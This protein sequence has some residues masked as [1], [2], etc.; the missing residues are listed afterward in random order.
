MA[1]GGALAARVLLLVGSETGNAQDA[2]EQVAREAARRGY[3]ARVMSMGDY[4]AEEL[5]GEAVVVLVVATT[6]QGEVPGSMKR[7]WRY[8]LR[9]SLPRDWLRGTCYAV[10]GLGDSAYQLFN[11][12][13]KKLDR[14][15]MDLG[16]VPLL[17]RGLGDD[18]HPCGYA[19]ALD[20]WLSS[21]WAV[22]P[23]PPPSASSALSAVDQPRL[24]VQVLS[25]GLAHAA[26]SPDAYTAAPPVAPPAPDAPIAAGDWVPWSKEMAEA[27]GMMDVALSA[28][29]TPHTSANAQPHSPDAPVSAPTGFTP[30][31]P[32]LLEATGAASPATAAASGDDGAAE[33]RRAF[34]RHHPFLATLEVNR[35]LTA[36]GHWQD[37]RHI[38]LNTHGGPEYSPGDVLHVFPSQPRSAVLA[39]LHRCNLHPHMQVVVRAAGLTPSSPAPARSMSL[40]SL[41]AATLDINSASPR[42]YFFE[43]LG[44]F[45]SDERE[46]EKLAWLASPEGRE[47]LHEYNQRERRT[48]LEVLQEFPS[49][50]LPL[51]WLLQ[52]CPRLQ[53]RSFSISSSPLAHPARCHLTAALVS[54]TT[55][56]K[57]TRLG[58]CSRWLASLLPGQAS[59]LP[60]WVTPGTLSLPPPS[61]PLIL[62][63]PGTGCAPFRSFI[64]QR[65]CLPAAGG[66]AT[67]AAGD[68]FAGVAGDLPAPILF[69]FGC[70][71]QYAD[72]LYQ[73]EWEQLAG[74]Q[75]HAGLEGS[76]GRE[77]GTAGSARGEVNGSAS[78]MGEAD[79]W[80]GVHGAEG[81]KESRVQAGMPQEEATGGVRSI[82]VG[83]QEEGHTDTPLSQDRGGGLF[84]A[85]SRDQPSK[86]Y[87][88][89]L[90]RA[91]SRQVWQ[92][93]Q[94]G[95]AVFI[96]GSANKM[97]ADVTR[98]LED[99]VRR[100]GG[101]EEEQA[102]VWVKALQRAGR[103]MV[104]A[105]S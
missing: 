95:A 16:A 32:A 89:H 38:E 103:L 17:P 63:G 46:Q 73:A 47:E 96:A 101:V 76:A 97:P 84:V 80:N 27:V 56:L 31:K 58:L 64:H 11:A 79:G 2:G 49:V 104:E 14:R 3:G 82:D 99:V 36:E 59:P 70:R 23:P 78:D 12:A 25:D 66:A 9:R 105:W 52:L 62:V 61:V 71:S 10:F 6:G 74:K 24:H 19:A 55:P 69:F 42:A 4:R 1:S 35:R 75:Q 15:M 51:P 5:P 65:A 68:G 87:V 29:W 37:V 91:N 57:R 83:R 50:A 20:V 93:L 53:P 85:F 41:I 88:Q 81:V 67:A 13:A 98:A 94:Q 77:E 8:L 22:L 92:F 40:L 102:R 86:V 90:I 30:D 44:R 48:V 45:A 7:F 54:V 39:L 28:P 72:N 100:E 18:Q 26:S 60:I 43:V 34:H 33:K 21:L